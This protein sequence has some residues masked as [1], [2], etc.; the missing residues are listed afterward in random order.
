MGD[1]PQY[2]RSLEMSEYAY[3]TVPTARPLYRAH[4]ARCIN[5]QAVPMPF[6]AFRALVRSIVL[7]A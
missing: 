4:V 5:A 3:P 6:E 2:Q 1:C 7:G